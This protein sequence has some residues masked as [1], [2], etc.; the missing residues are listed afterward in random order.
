MTAP[1]TQVTVG[2]SA[3]PLAAVPPGGWALFQ[4]QGSNDCFVS[5]DAGVTTSTGTLFLQNA[6]I[7][8]TNTGDTSDSWYGI[9]ASSTT[10]VSVIT[11]P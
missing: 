11:G 5:P 3:T 8:V 7:T 9:T 1:S 2:N 4:N 6:T 10:T